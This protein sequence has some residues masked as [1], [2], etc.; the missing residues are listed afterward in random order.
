MDIVSLKFKSV[1]KPKMQD[2]TITLLD[3]G[4]EEAREVAIERG[5]KSVWI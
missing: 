3:A 4:Y 2:I 1:D 5:V